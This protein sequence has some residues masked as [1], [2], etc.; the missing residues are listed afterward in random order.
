M[1]NVQI[2]KF[3]TTYNAT[4]NMSE[5]CRY[6]IYPM[7]EGLNSAA[8]ALSAPPAA[9]CVEVTMPASQFKKMVEA[10]EPLENLR[11][12][13]IDMPYMYKLWKTQRREESAR[14]NNPVVQAAYNEYQMLIGLTQ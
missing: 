1:D 14:K 10:Q 13:G 5:Q 8:Q 3:M 7:R 12:A 6:Q 9:P 2:K 4:V 11:L